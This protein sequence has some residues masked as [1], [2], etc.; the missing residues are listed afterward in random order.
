MEKCMKKRYMSLILVSLMGCS[1]VN[2]TKTKSGYERI[3]VSQTEY[4]KPDFYIENVKSLK[5]SRKIASVVNLEGEKRFNSLSNR[6]LYFLTI[7]KQYQNFGTILGKSASV[8]SCPSFHGV[9]LDNESITKANYAMYTSNIDL[10]KVE[11]HPSLVTSYPIM[12]IPYSDSEDLYS[13]LENKGYEKDDIYL[14]EALNNYYRLQE[15]E[16]EV[17]C[18]KGVSPGYYIYENLVTYFKQ[19]ASFHSTKEGLKALLKVPVLANMLILDNLKKDSYDFSN[20]GLIED[21][22]LKR[23]QTSW[24]K[25]YLFQVNEKRKS[26]LSRSYVE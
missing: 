9:L 21:W 22:L 23:S 17:L 1:T 14:S 13:R 7:Y 2:N 24:F 15:K 16:V 20:N 25:N 19:D 4:L 11:N 3:E 26:H 6:Q 18:D 5:K 8:N 12:A 10:S